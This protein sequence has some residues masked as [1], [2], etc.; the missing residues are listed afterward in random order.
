M[1]SHLQTL[2]QASSNVCP[3][4]NGTPLYTQKLVVGVTNGFGAGVLTPGTGAN[5]TWGAGVEQSGFWQHGFIGSLTS[6]H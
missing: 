1:S 4:L 3:F 5:V 2:S 6:L